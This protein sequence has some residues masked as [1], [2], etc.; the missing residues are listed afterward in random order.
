MKD[1]RTW[2]GQPASI[3]TADEQA[4]LLAVN[5]GAISGGVLTVNYLV[6]SYAS[7]WASDTVPFYDDLLTEQDVTDPLKLVEAAR[8]RLAEREVPALEVSVSAADLFKIDTQEARPGLGDTVTLVDPA[9]GLANITARIT[10]MTEYPYAPD[11]HTS[12]TVANVM[13]RDYTQIIADLEAGRRAIE[14][15]FSGGRIRAEVFEEFARRAVIEINESKTEVKYDTR[16]IVL[17]STA[18]ANDQVILT[19]NGIIITTDGGATARSAITA[20]RVVAESIVGQLGSFVSMVIGADNNVVKINTNGISA[21]HNDFASAPFRLDMAGNLVANSLTANYANILSSNFTDG[22]IVGSSINV[23]SGRFTVSAAG[24]VYTEGGVYSGGT[25]TGATIQTATATRRI[26]LDAD[27]FSSYDGSGVRRIAIVT[28]DDFGVQAMQYYG[29]GGTLSGLVD[30]RDGYLNV[31]AAGSTLMLGGP[32]I[33]IGG[34][35]SFPT[36]NV[37]LGDFVSSFDFNNVTIAGA[38]RIDDLEWGAYNAAGYNLAFDTT[39]RN[40]KMYSRN[41]TLMATVNIPA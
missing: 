37:S 24:D 17:Q 8:T 35:V 28:D 19:S 29:P 26:K 5:P 6:S 16:G 4:R 3:L 32:S 20:G 33:V 18:D 34:D 14:N 11:K 1:S 25:I 2:I 40:L 13:R 36:F 12:L 7:A 30:G 21:G 39:T 22:A 10:E 23:G 15:V 31:S 9:L 27:G 41:G 38:P